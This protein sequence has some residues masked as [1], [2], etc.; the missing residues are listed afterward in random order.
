MSEKTKGDAAIGAVVECLKTASDA[1][2]CLVLLQLGGDA[3]VKVRG[4]QS[5]LQEALP[6]AMAAKEHQKELRKKVSGLKARLAASIAWEEERATYELQRF[7]PGVFAYRRKR[8]SLAPQQRLSSE[9]EHLLCA[10]CFDKRRK[11]VLQSTPKIER[12]YQVHMCPECKN[13]FA[14]Y[15]DANGMGG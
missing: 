1:A 12:R 8:L 7:D 14:F 11:S 3:Y 10:S 15:H 4:L 2:K 6:A 5:T 9:A 13:E